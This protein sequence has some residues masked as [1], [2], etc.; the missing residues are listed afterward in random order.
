M[1][2]FELSVS[3]RSA[4]GT[5]CSFHLHASAGG[6]GFHRCGIGPRS[7]TFV[8]APKRASLPALSVARYRV[9]ERSL[10]SKIVASRIT[11]AKACLLKQGASEPECMIALNSVTK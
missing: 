9:A 4:S 8:G 2:T 11:P 5:A 3:G 6:T 7:P 1:Y 10:A